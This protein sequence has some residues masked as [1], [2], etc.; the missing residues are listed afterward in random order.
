MGRDF[1]FRSNNSAFYNNFALFWTI[2]Q[3]FFD[4]GNGGFWS[5]KLPSLPL[6]RRSRASDPNFFKLCLTRAHLSLA[7]DYLGFKKEQ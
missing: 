4:T 6:G 3:L 2:Q 5:T 7:Y 1:I